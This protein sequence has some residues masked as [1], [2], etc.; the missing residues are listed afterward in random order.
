MDHC[1]TGRGK[2]AFRGEY[3]N[4]DIIE[5]NEKRAQEI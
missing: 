4:F 3:P 5:I 2:R 1:Y